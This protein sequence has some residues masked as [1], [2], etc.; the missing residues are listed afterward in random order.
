M[1]TPIGFF[2]PAGGG[3]VTDG[4]TGYFDAGDASSY[5]GTG[6]T[7]YDLSATGQN[8][9]WSSNPSGIHTS[10]DTGYFSLSSSTRYRATLTAAVP[11]TTWWDYTT[12]EVS[13]EF[14]FKSNGF[15]NY[16]YFLQGFNNLNSYLSNSSGYSP[17]GGSSLYVQ[18]NNGGATVQQG[19]WT[20]TLSSGTWYHV[21]FSRN[22][23]GGYV[24]ING[25]RNT[26]WSSL[27]T[28]NVAQTGTTLGI[29]WTGNEYLNSDYALLRIYNR[30]LT[31]AEGD[32]QY[33]Y[34]KNTRGY[35]I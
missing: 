17:V 32:Q 35:S 25:S 7:W 11:N 2:A 5:P 21:I 8:L 6:T 34:Y 12:N 20:G 33:D 27:T 26:S 3:Q 30:A 19:M 16:Q 10:G 29:G 28:W 1:F 18:F 13:L 9:T 31:T 15:V 4:L 24:Q 22:G 23:N 14:L